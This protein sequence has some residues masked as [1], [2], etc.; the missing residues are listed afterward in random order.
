MKPWERQEH[1]PYGA[2]LIGELAKRNMTQAE[3]ARLLGV[4]RQYVSAII[5]GI[6]PG[7]AVIPQI[8]AVLGKKTPAEVAYIPKKKGRKRI[9]PINTNPPRKRGRPRKI[10]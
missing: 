3:L 2:W 4:T 6:Q 5:N 9:K 8:E 7:L 10:A 1:S